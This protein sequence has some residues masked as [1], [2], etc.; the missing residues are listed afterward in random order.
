MAVSL[1]PYVAQVHEL[2]S[3]SLGAGYVFG[4]LS[5]LDFRKVA[6]A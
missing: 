3:K 2:L 5:L 1:D 6:D 4:I